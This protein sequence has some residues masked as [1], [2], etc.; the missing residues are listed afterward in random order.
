MS[1]YILQTSIGDYEYPAHMQRHPDSF[2]G[3]NFFKKWIPN[4][5]NRLGHLTKKEVVVCAF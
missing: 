3:S 2:F 5:K 1:E 4:W